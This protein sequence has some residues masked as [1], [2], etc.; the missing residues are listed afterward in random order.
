VI[1]AAD[2]VTRLSSRG[3][4]MRGDTPIPGTLLT[5]GGRWTRVSRIR[6]CMNNDDPP[7]NAAVVSY[8]DASSFPQKCGNRSKECADTCNCSVK[9]RGTLTR[10]RS[11]RVLRSLRLYRF[12]F[13]AASPPRMYRP[14]PF[15]RC[16]SSLLRWSLR[17]P[18]SAQDAV[19][20]E[21]TASPIHRQR[22]GI[23][24]FGP[25]DEPALS[26]ASTVCGSKSVRK[27]HRNAY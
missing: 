19:P 18:S 17:L 15:V 1:G 23:K 10:T 27:T 13:Q 12:N 5:G 8:A 26:R 6:S 2:A 21:R 25:L 4:W 3:R 16:H 14:A 22:S 9:S 7:I 24:I 11:T 20:Q